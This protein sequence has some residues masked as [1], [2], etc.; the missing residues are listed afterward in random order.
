MLFRSQ[1]EAALLQAGIPFKSFSYG[2]LEG[3]SIDVVLRSSYLSENK[4]NHIVV[5][6]EK[7]S[8]ASDAIRNISLLSTNY[9]IVGYGSNR[10]RNFETIELEA[11]QNVN[12]H[13]SLGYFVDYKL[14]EVKD[15]V[16]K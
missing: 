1:V 11:F 15:F 10:L 5:A 12:M 2:I 6:S 8:F 7:E 9:D 4:T 14:P 16:F 3:R 13:F